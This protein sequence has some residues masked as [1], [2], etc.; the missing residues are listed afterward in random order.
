MLID[1]G[2]WLKKTLSGNSV[3][4]ELPLNFFV[5]NFGF[6]ICYFM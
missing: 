4:C 6:N 2:D 3:F 5:I 1:K